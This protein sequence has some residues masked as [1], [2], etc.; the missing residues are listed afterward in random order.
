MKKLIVVMLIL[1]LIAAL[2]ACGE[3]TA[4]VS[5]STVTTPDTSAEDDQSEDVSKIKIGFSLANEGAFYDQLVLDIEDECTSMNYEPQIMTA[6]SVEQQQEDIS[7]LL[8]VG[9]AV[10]VIEPVDVDALE[11]VLA[12]C[13]TQEVPVIDIIDSVNGLVKM[14]ISPDYIA[15]GERVGQYAV[16]TFGETGGSCLM[17]KTQYDSFTMQLMS[18]G[19]NAAIDEDSDVSLASEQFCGNDEEQAY[20]LTN[21]ALTENA[22]INFIFAQS[23]VIAR[24]ALRAIQESGSDISLVAYGGDMDMIEAV[25]SGEMDAALFSGPS[26]LAERAVFYANQ[27]IQNED[28][29][30]PQFEELD[31]EMVDAGNASEYYTEDEAYAE[32]KGE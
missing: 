23:A 27:L 18:D 17:L 16:D 3:D 4:E 8:S 10:I 13:E 32:I 31:V 7:S 12:E 5:A 9:V 1:L 15:V 14:L 24:G 2:C 22:N 19:F 28:Y 21:Q 20:S 11:S 29:A 6:D 25:V 26:Q 30:S